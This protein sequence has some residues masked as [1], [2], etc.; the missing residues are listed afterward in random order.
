LSIRLAFTVNYITPQKSTESAVLVSPRDADREVTHF[1]GNYFCCG[2]RIRLRRN[3]SL[4][5]A[6]ESARKYFKYSSAETSTARAASDFPERS[7][8]DDSV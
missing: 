8:E 4:K 1:S 5:I 2:F 6:Q 3:R 7:G